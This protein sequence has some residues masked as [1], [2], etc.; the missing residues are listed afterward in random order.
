MTKAP[1]LVVMAAGMGS[2]YGGLKQIDPISPQGE[3]IL[4]FSIYDARRAGFEKFV[5]IIKRELEA[6]FEEVIGRRL[7][8]QVPLA[9]AY[10][11]L[12]DLP[13]G[14]FVPS[15]RQKPWGTSHAVRAARGHIDGPFAVI[16]ADDFYGADAFRAMFGFLSSRQNPGGIPQYA[17]V[18]YKLGNT[19][20][21]HGSVARGCCRAEGD[22]LVEI[23]ERT[24]IIKKDG[25]A[26]FSEDAGATWHPLALDIPVSMQFFGFT[27][28]FFDINEKHFKS[29][30]RLPAPDPLKNE[31]YLPWVVGQ[32]V[33]AGEARVRI[34]PSHDH[35]FGVTY[36]QDKPYVV[37]SVAGLRR[38]GAYPEA[39]W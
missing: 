29:F 4:D 23:H 38:A 34:L 19:L 15:G 32:A 30:L 22:T 25:A 13:E 27:P 18:G 14:F 35:W 26:A 3:V 28:D 11:E 33:T 24:N 8:H 6:D 9:Y 10:Q 39:L 7:R 16:N 17:M 1:A 5:L 2:R 37:E 12:E 31:C 36:P 20:T 21:D